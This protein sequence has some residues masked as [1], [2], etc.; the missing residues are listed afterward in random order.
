MKIPAEWE[1]VPDDSPMDDFIYAV[2]GGKWGTAGNK[3]YTAKTIKTERGKITTA[4]IK[5]IHE[6]FVSYHGVRWVNRY[7][8]TDGRGTELSMS[9]LCELNDGS[10]AWVTAWNDYTGWGCQDGVDIYVGTREE[11]INNCMTKGERE[12]LGL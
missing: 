5:E 8:E 9:V 12:E 11:I 4:D 10:W 2:D 3:Y 6:W 7:P 1:E